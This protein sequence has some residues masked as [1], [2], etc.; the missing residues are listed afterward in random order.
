VKYVLDTN[1]VS[2]VLNVTSVCSVRLLLWSR[3]TWG[4]RCSCSP[5]CSSARR[6]PAAESRT[7]NASRCSPSA[8]PCSI[9]LAIVQRYAIVRADVERR[10]RRKSDFDLI[11]AC[12]AIEHS[13]AL[14][15]NDAALKD[16]TIDGL[17]VEDWLGG[18]TS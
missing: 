17:V 6:S 4:F 15:T 16:G 12:T 3:T 18:G 8:S 14:V 5:S 9:G 7:V 13:A 1:V 10:G 11:I 2:R